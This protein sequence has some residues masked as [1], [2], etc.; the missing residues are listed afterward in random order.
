MN[1]LTFFRNIEFILYLLFSL[2]LAFFFQNNFL[3]S[4]DASILFR[5]SENFADTGIISY[6]LNEPPVEGVTDFLWMLILSAFYFIGIDTYFSAIVINLI[7]LYFIIKLIQK[8]YLLSKLDF[9]LLF[10]FHFT[11]TQTYSAILGFSVLFVEL[12]LVLVILNFLKKRIFATLFYSFVGCLIRP[13]FILFIIIPNLVNLIQ[14]LNLKTVRLY[15]CFILLGLIYF[16]LR[17]KYFGLLFPL[18][19]YIKNQWVAFNN[20]EWAR[21]IIILSPSLLILFYIQFKKIFKKSITI[22]LSIGI[23]ATSYYSNQL[24]YQ[25][26]GYRFYFYFPILTIL[27]LY[28][29]QFDFIKLKKIVRNIVFLVSIFS[30]VINLSQNFKSLSPI[31]K[32]NNDI[33]TI[34]SELKK[35][36]EKNKLHMATTEAGLLPYYSGIHTIDL[37][38]LNTKEFAKK[39]ADGKV[40]RENNFDLIIINSSITGENCESLLLSIQ[41]AKSMKNIDSKRSDDWSIFSKKLLSGINI[42]KYDAF[43]LKYPKNIF[44]NKH[45]KAYV[46]ISK[47]INNKKIYKCNFN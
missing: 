9:Y 8:Y 40:L 1:N 16:F 28:E 15:I 11:L 3:P 39:P 46:E 33:H 42:Q 38:G 32:K 5:Y 12:I 18:P 37:F 19:F 26:V 23:L 43:F 30:F 45:S 2:L 7:S 36:N 22:I 4:E 14:N 13:D 20:L 27:I 34:S 47:V 6:N 25:N 44:I 10:F 29:I 35:I 24:L 31:M 21:Q 41:E 17:Y